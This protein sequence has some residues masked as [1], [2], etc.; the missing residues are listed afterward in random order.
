M[1]NILKLDSLACQESALHGLG[2][3]QHRYSQT[4]EKIIAE[5]ITRQPNLRPELWSYAQSA[6]TGC[7]L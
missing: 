2:H 5:F 6:R 7:V 4:V 3:W 1:E